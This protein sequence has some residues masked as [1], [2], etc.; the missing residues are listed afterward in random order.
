MAVTVLAFL[1]CYVPTTLILV[2]GRLRFHESGWYHFLA[3]FIP[4][5]SSG[6]NPIIYCF[7]TRRFRAALKQLLKDPCG[8]SPFQETNQVQLAQRVTSPKYP[9]RQPAASNRITNDPEEATFVYRARV[10]VDQRTCC[11]TA[12]QG[13]CGSWI[14]DCKEAE[15]DGNNSQSSG[16]RN[17]NTAVPL[18]RQETGGGKLAWME[19]LHTDSAEA[20]SCLEED[21]P[22]L[23]GNLNRRQEVTVEQNTQKEHPVPKDNDFPER[24]Y[25]T[26]EYQGNHGKKEHSCR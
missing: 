1:A 9:R 21:G 13:Q 7:R 11:A 22:A 19:N 20:N 3:Q 24:N 2:T 23:C 10:T 18:H 4:L 25:Q 14:E 6:I 8:R 5:I 26:M 12:A 16:L 15:R 17:H